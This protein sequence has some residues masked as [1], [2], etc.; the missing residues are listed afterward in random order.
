GP[1]S[2][3][4]QP[5]HRTRRAAY[6][7]RNLVLRSAPRD[8]VREHEKRGEQHAVGQQEQRQR[9]RDG[10]DGQ[11]RGR[12]GGAQQPLHDPRLPSAFGGHPSRDDNNEAERRREQ[13][14]PMITIRSVETPAPP[15]RQTPPRE[16][17]QEETDREHDAETEKYHGDRR[18]ILRRHGV[19]SL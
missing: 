6:L 16:R 15:Q 8:A 18:A 2:L 11:G 13:A 4:T 1:C 9:R 17:Q 5:P 19:E 10:T 7:F 3:R 14:D 12:V